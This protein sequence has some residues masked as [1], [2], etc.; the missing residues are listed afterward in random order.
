MKIINT[1]LII[2]LSSFLGTCQN[3]IDVCDK[4]KILTNLSVV[5]K[6][7]KVIMQTSNDDCV[8][9]LIDTLANGF[10]ENKNR[11]YIEILDSI[12]QSGDGYI[13][14]YLYD[15][16]AKLALES[17]DSFIEYLSL[18]KEGCCFE[19][20][21]LLVMSWK[22]KDGSSPRKDRLINLID[23]K[24]KSTIIKAKTKICLENLRGKLD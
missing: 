20:K 14:E 15:I 19:R 22:L 5:R 11:E 7:I 21:L 2:W 6:N 13:G 3:Q 1:L 17:F 18:Q 10:I 8:L 9:R 4:E 12:C 24:L 23:K 16:T